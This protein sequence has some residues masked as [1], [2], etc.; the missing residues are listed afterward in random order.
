M[1]KVDPKTGVGAGVADGGGEG[2][3]VLPPLPPAAKYLC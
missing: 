3:V 1:L 2:G